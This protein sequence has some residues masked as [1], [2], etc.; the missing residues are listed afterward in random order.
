MQKTI[1]KRRAIRRH[2]YRRLR[3]KRRRYWFGQEGQHDSRSLGM[4][5]TTP[6]PCSCRGC[7]NPRKHENQKTIQERR[8]F[9]GGD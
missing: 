1:I 7:G 9:Q 3:K 4:V 2:H 5:V 6:H 8:N